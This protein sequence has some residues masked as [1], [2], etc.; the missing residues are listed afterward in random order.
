MPRAFCL[1]RAEPSYRRES[2]TAGLK[3][4][5]FEIQGNCQDTPR[6][7]DV[8]VI[9]NRY[10]GFH[11]QANHFEKHG[12]RVIVAENGLLGRSWLGEPWYSLALRNPAGAGWWPSGGAE[13]WQSFGV[14]PCEWRKGGTEAIVLG[15]R[16]IGPPGIAQPQGWDL[17]ALN[18]LA[19]SGEVVRLRRH[20][21]ERPALE[22][23][24]D[25]K[26][27]KYVVAWSSGAALRALLWGI[28]VVYGLEQWIG[29]PAA[30]HWS[31]VAAKLP[32][33]PRPDSME[34][35][36][37]TMF[38]RLGWTIWRTREIETGEPF[39]RLLGSDSGDSRTTP[40]R[41]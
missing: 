28:P 36:R 25:L 23:Q 3:A 11:N 21:G 38:A 14:E 9:W 6:P 1:I 29:A 24:D 17:K 39:R 34:L 31:S 19:S 2:F 12:A 32:E 5:G 27:A 4:V 33:L 13:R 22:L 40:A 16:G 41:T 7:D 10:G 30:R 8:L 18:L 15:Q 35:E 20:P 37:D 26:N